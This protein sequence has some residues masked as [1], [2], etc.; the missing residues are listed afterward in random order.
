M[1]AGES[2]AGVPTDELAGLVRAAV[3][4]L[5]AGEGLPASEA[6]GRPTRAGRVRPARGR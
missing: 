2:F 4:D 3:R 1:G 5:L 6:P